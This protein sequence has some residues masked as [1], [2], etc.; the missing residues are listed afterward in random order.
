MQ[1]ISDLVK[2]IFEIGI[3]NEESF[4]QLI[5][6]NAMSTELCTMRDTLNTHMSSSGT[7]NTEE[8]SKEQLLVIRKTERSNTAI[9]NTARITG[10]RNGPRCATHGCHGIHLMKNCFA[11]G[12]PMEGRRDEVLAEPKKAREKMEQEKKDR[13]QKPNTGKTKRFVDEN[14]TAYTLIEETAGSAIELTSNVELHA[15]ANQY[16][17]ISDDELSMALL[18]LEDEDLRAPVDW[19]E[20]EQLFNSYPSADYA[21]KGISVP[22]L[23]PTVPSLTA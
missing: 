6:L 18:E 5:L 12:G 19:K 7:A 9:A 1:R 20:H 23:T 2:H 11:K 22:S 8:Q 10:P 17:D 13:D 15:L 14:G 3:P 16:M 21:K 4:H